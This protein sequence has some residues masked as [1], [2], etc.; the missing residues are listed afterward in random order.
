MNALEPLNVTREV[1]NALDVL[2]TVGKRGPESREALRWAINTLDEAGV[3]QEIDDVIE[4]EPTEG[5]GSEEFRE[6][7]RREELATPPRLRELD[8]R[9][10]YGEI[11][12][13]EYDHEIKPE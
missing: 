9:L 7:M 1:I 10:A 12:P 5:Y 8:R 11:S 6:E 13:D 2:R 3:F 4:S